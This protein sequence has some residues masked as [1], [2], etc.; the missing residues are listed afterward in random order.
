MKKKKV[1]ISYDVN[2]AVIKSRLEK[3]PKEQLILHG[4]Y[5]RLCAWKEE[6]GSNKR[7]MFIRLYEF[8]R[9][10]YIKKYR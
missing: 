2:P 6:Q 4:R 1:Q 7:A 9:W 8:C 5:I 10:L 3:L